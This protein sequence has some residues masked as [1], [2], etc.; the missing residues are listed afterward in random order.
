MWKKRASPAP[1]FR[2]PAPYM[3]ITG[4]HA[5]IGTEGILSFCAMMQIVGDDET[6]E[7]EDTHDNYVV[8]RGFDPDTRKFYDPINVAKP[9]GVRGTHPY[10]L[11]EVHPAIKA[12][13]RIGD[14]PGVCETT[15]GHPADLDETI[16]ILRDDE[17]VAI[18]WL[19]LDT[20]IGRFTRFEL[21]S[22]LVNGGTATANPR[23]WDVAAGED[24]ADTD[25]EITVWDYIG[26]REGAIGHIGTG[27]R[28]GGDPY[29]AVIDL[30]CP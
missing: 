28:L 1:F 9:Y 11:A 21:T 7:N 25:T 18:E 27:M 17:G 2:M 12:R 6:E 4:K 8:C 3:P 29:Y 10:T 30:E 16:E 24:V 19:L 15:V 20:G 14:T 13:T 5:P 23:R 26:D 22:A